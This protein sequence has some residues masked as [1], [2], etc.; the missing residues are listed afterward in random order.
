VEKVDSEK[1]EIA[2]DAKEKLKHCISFYVVLLTM[3][4]Q[5]GYTK[6]NR[7]R[8]KCWTQ[9]Q[10]DINQYH[11][12]EW[13]FAR[14]ST[15]VDFMDMT[16]VIQDN[17]I[18]TDLFEKKMALYLYI[19]PHSAHSPGQLTGLVMG[20]VLRIFSLCSRTVDKQMHTYQ[21][22]LV[23]VRCGYSHSDLLPLLE[24][25][26]TNSEAF[27]GKS[28]EDKARE[29]CQKDEDSSKRIF[30]HLKYHP[31]DN[32]PKSSAIQKAFRE[33]IMH[34]KGDQPFTELENER[35]HKIPLDRLTV[36]Y[37]KHSNLGSLND[38]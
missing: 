21:E 12:L 5:S 23:L 37:S 29:K 20:Q 32:D 10:E 9:F 33:S 13:T 17:G 35:G 30:L 18:I 6:L 24:K 7:R 16:L 15:T 11:G 28:E 38:D 31:N 26:A 25:A 2:G 34:P 1:A 36:C 3:A 19:P 27:I 14:R 8:K 22:L 4:L